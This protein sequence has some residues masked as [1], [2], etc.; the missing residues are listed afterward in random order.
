[1]NL[2]IKQKSKINNRLK[3]MKLDVLNKYTGEI[4]ES[5]EADTAETIKEKIKRT[6]QWEYK[7]LNTTLEDRI[8]VIKDISNVLIKEKKRIKDLIVAEGG[9]PIK[10]SEQIQKSICNT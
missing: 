1:M 4:I 8:E 10:Y 6:A 7:L 2:K 5:L 3:D 9:L